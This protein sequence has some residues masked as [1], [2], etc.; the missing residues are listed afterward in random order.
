MSAP[1][2]TYFP[3]AGR[4]E[5]IRLIAAAGDVEVTESTEMQAGESKDAYLTPSGTP[6]LRHGELRMSQSLA[7]ENYIAAISPKF[8]GLTPQQR[9]IDQMYGGI[10]EEI[11]FNCAKA[12]FTTRKAD[13]EQASKDVTA[14]LD[15]WFAILEA[16]VPEDGFIQG[17]GFPTPADLALVNI[18][19]AYMP[20]GAA[21]KHAGYD[22]AKFPKVM[23]LCDRAAKSDGVAAYL[24][25]SP[26]TTANPMNM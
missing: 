9:A 26:Y 7:I 24:E 19:G 8:G 2:M 21:V 11:L 16:K 25:K 3:L 20:F 12:I 6:I 1:H 15:K 22:I 23:A 5:L 17:L 14:L 10:K 13:P 4:A 18:T